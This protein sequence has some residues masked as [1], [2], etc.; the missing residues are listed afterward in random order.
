MTLSGEMAT[1][2][3]SAHTTIGAASARIG[4][5]AAAD[6]QPFPVDRG[7]VLRSLGVLFFAALMLLGADMLLLQL[8]SSTYPVTVGNYRDE[9]FL[10]G[11]HYQ[12]TADDGSTYRWTEA[13]SLL[14]LAHPGVAPGAVL[15]L[16]LGG[17]PEPGRLDL[18]LNGRPWVSLTADTQ[19]RRYA[20]M[21]PPDTQEQLAVG[22]T[23][24]TFR[25]EG[26]PRA[27]GVKF[28]RFSITV[29]RDRT[30]LPSGAQYMLQLAI[31]V[32]A[33]LTLVRLGWDW[34]RQGMLLLPLALAL[35]A[36]LSSALLVIHSY[37]PNLAGAAA[38]LAALTW[39]GL[40]LAERHLGGMGGVRE[41]RLLWALMLLACAVRLIGVLYPSFDGQDLGR[42][43][44]R[45]LLTI[46][47]ELVI[48][49]P[50]SEFARG[51][52]IYPTGPYIA[53]MPLLTF[54]GDIWQY[55]EGAM[56]LIDGTSA[57]L[58][59]M[60]AWRLGGGR[61]A[62]RIALLLYLASVASYSGLVYQFSAQIFG[63]WFTAPIA[64]LLLAGSGDRPDLRRWGL[65]LIL[66]QFA[67]Y[68]HI[69]VSILGVSWFGA[70]LLLTLLRSRARDVWI[71][72]GLFFGAVALSVGFLYIH[73]LELTLTHAGAV[74]QQQ[75]SGGSG[76]LFPGASPL[77][78]RGARLAYADIGLALIPIGLLFALSAPGAW[79][80][81]IVL[82]GALIVIFFYLIV[83]ALFDLQVRYYYFSIPFAMAL[84]GLVLGRVAARGGAGRFAAWALTA[85]IVADGLTQWF[86]ATFGDYVI[87][88]TPLTH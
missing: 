86:G 50:S 64:L 39:L 35:A 67:L 62:A 37:L 14:A 27:L 7:G 58:V 36:L 26:D 63:Q 12:E 30:L 60:L 81:R 70:M 68:S 47:G 65:A 23:S 42:N 10:Q 46:G 52:T 82:G 69:G 79:K 43:V 34:R 73:I 66:L 85:W 49:A 9:F 74:T 57:F 28:E 83:N 38:A 4:P 16:Q 76:E 32:A 18:T 15:T 13:Q 87:S 75:I 8:R 84:M 59:A 41:V 71:A 31:I 56:A 1:S 40:P 25:V 29:L 77:M 3:L 48:I 11:A 6:T 22:M 80:R 5:A 24:E 78:L 51:I 61:T 45:L 44:R 53:A 20:L 21:L 72:W 17:R 19:P 55:L 2:N 54:V 33:Q 88:M